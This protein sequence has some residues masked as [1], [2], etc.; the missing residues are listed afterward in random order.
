MGGARPHR[1]AASLKFSD[2]ELGQSPWR[3]PAR[4]RVRGPRNNLAHGE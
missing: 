4:D 3:H 1:G 2:A